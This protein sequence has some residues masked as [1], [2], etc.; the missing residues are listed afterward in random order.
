MKVVLFLFSFFVFH[1]AYAQAPLLTEDLI[2]KVKVEIKNLKSIPDRA[3]DIAF[4]FYVNNRKSVG[5]LKDSACLMQK[6]Y[7]IR[8]QDPK[9][10]KENLLN[11]VL[12]EGCIC[13]VD[14]T[15]PKT[16][17]RGSCVFLN[18]TGLEKIEN[19]PVAHGSGSIEKDGVP[20][21]FT[22]KLTPT[23]TTLSG[24]H[25]TAVATSV[26]GGKEKSVGPYRSTGLSLYGLESSNWTASAVGKVTHGAP[27]VVDSNPVVIGHSL[28]CPAMPMELAKKMLPRCQGQ[29]VWLNYTLDDKER[30]STDFRSCK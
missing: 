6:G 9:Q 19:F 8:A 21:T 15:R 25:L 11:G 13:I 17:K 27:Y 4:D 29:A 7:V 18:K 16:D 26:F 30:K 3:V 20:I 14:F 23:G 2:Q 22:N 12:N 5:G 24:L 10:K 28:G 1:Y